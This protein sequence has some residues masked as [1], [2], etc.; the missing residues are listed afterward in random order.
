M[1]TQDAM[2]IIRGLH[3]LRK[4]HKGC[5]ATLG[6][7]DG[8]HLAHKE[9]LLKLCKH[10]FNVK[11]PSCVIIFEPQPREFLTPLSA[12]SRLLL[13]RDKL[14]IFSKIGINQ[15]L[16]LP[17]NYFLSSLTAQEFIDTVLVGG[18]GVTHLVIG[19]DFRFGYQRRG[20]FSFLRKVSMQEGFTIDSSKSLKRDGVRISST[21]IREAL[22]KAD[23]DLAE[24]LLGRPFQIEGRVVHGERVGHKIG[25]PTANINLKRQHI[26]LKGVYVITSKIQE[27]T[28]HG[29]A[30]I[31]FRPTVSL[32]KKAHLE[33]HLLNYQGNLYNQI[34]AI[35][36]HHKL[37]N[38]EKF[39]SLDALKNAI[40]GDVACAK[41]YILK[42]NY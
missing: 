33:V 26:P 32:Q 23:F 38:E 42:I 37:R 2:K 5:V 17:F 9:I 21:I 18:L 35:D 13:L 19:D 7:F 28:Y 14:K 41:S 22:S 40:H 10:S 24:R 34:L 11:L 31:G 4:E 16:C 29:L 15:V 39:P 3:N 6:N 36:F 12:P 8:V 30:N 25:F 1:G 20:D 27:K